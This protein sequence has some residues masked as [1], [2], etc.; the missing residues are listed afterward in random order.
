MIYGHLKLSSIKANLNQTI[1]KANPIGILGQ[2]FSY[3]T[4][5]ERKHLH[6]GIHKGT[7]ID[8]RG[9][10]QNQSELSVWIDYT[11]LLK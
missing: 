1:D 11:T 4:D 2:G 7:L 10:V 8:L 6:L 3:E 9:Y 5:N